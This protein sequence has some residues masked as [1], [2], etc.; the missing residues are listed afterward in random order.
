MTS[1]VR[2]AVGAAACAALL[3]LTSQAGAAPKLTLEGFSRPAADWQRGAGLTF[4]RTAVAGDPALAIG[5]TRGETGWSGA[6]ARPLPGGAGAAVS[7]DV[8]L[9]QGAEAGLFGA[10]GSPPPLT[11][12]A[13]ARGLI[14]GAGNRRVRVRTRKLHHVEATTDGG[15][16]S[17]A[18]DGK[19]IDVAGRAPREFTLQLRRGRLVLDS[20]IASPSRDPRSLLLHRLAALHAVTPRGRAPLGVGTDGRLRFHG[21]WTRGFWP[22]ALWQAADLTRSDV[23]ERWALRATLDNFG[24]ERED[25]HDLGFMYGRSSVAAYER[26]CRTP[27]GKRSGDAGTC[28]RL[29]RSA[30]TAADSLAALARTNEAAGT[31]PTRSATPCRGCASLAEADT[32]VDSMMN[33]PLLLWAARETPAERSAYRDVA[34]RHASGVAQHLVRADGSTAQSVHTRRDDGSVIGV[35]THQGASDTG[36]W[37]RGQSWAVYG[38][39]ETALLTR[40]PELLAVAECAAG[41]IAARDPNG[42]VPPYD[43]DAGP[44]APTDAS[45]GV[46][47]AAGLLRLEDACRRL[48]GCAD[49]GRRWHELGRRLIDSSVAQVGRQPPLGLLGGQVLSLGGSS[50][51][52][53]RGEFIFGLD[54]ALEALRG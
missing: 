43:Y 48:G 49:G 5:R 17:V 10:S 24:A 11:L 34:L 23:F 54:F 26:L 36:T 4:R 3:G 18:V 19:P 8:G 44:G 21:G 38:F 47:A 14:V 29:R 2:R 33:V 45:A 37:A 6:L 12:R 20:F 30:L 50:T 40:S 22:G 46:I 32:I 41:Y 25:T 9:S 16:L 1:R 31:I 42:L 13:S 7:V 27:K 39:A 15:Q 35:H 51:W 52:D 28:E 53:D